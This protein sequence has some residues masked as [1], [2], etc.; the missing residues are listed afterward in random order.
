MALRN[1]RD[2]LVEGAHPDAGEIVETLRDYPQ[3]LSPDQL[4]QMIWGADS[5]DTVKTAAMDNLLTGMVRKGT[6][7]VQTQK[8]Y[9]APSEAQEPPSQPLPEGPMAPEI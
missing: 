2:H 4:A 6:I 7:T 1:Y 9:F 5:S 8:T 3:G